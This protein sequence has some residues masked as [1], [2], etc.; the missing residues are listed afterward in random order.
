MLAFEIIK[1]IFIG[2]SCI[3]VFV[4]ISWSIIDRKFNYNTLLI[5]CC[6]VLLLLVLGEGYFA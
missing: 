6:I 4:G 3:G 1:V 2:V 5:L